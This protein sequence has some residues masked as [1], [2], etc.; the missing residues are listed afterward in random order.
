MRETLE[1]VQQQAYAKGQ[2]SKQRHRQLHCM[3]TTE[4]AITTLSTDFAQVSLLTFLRHRAHLC[5]L[6]FHRG[7]LEQ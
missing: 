4:A 6:A 3:L 1:L 5:A 7:Y 2:Q